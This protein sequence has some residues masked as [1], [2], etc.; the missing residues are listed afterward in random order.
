MLKA[1]DLE[2]RV[3]CLL[4]HCAKGLCAFVPVFVL[5]VFRLWSWSILPKCHITNRLH[6]GSDHARPADA[7]G[8][9][10]SV[11]GGPACCLCFAAILNRSLR[12]SEGYS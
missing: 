5:G 3:A 2:A 12:N 11:I 7:E 1:M 10:P 8:L 9:L 4:G 6:I